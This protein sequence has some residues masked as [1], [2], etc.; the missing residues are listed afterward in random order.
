L[1][2]ILPQ[3]DIAFGDGEVLTAGYSVGSNQGSSVSVLD[4]V[5][6]I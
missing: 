5:K 3:Q 4:R 2:I 1:N 6:F